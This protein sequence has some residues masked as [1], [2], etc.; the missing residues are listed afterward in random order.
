MKDLERAASL[1]SHF[2]ISKL[3]CLCI[4]TT[5]LGKTPIHWLIAILLK[6][7]ALITMLNH[8]ISY[9]SKLINPSA[10]LSWDDQSP[11]RFRARILCMESHSVPYQWTNKISGNFGRRLWFKQSTK[12]FDKNPLF[13]I[14]QPNLSISCKIR[15][16]SWSKAIFRFLD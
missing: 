8:F 10:H 4:H 16:K 6:Q 11:V 1:I 14:K 5:W 12:L 7:T 9:L 15:W 2:C 3:P 13:S